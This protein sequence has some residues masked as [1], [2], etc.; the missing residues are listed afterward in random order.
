[1]KN[2][3][4]SNNNSSTLTNMCY[5]GIVDRSYFSGKFRNTSVFDV[6]TYANSFTDIVDNNLTDQNN[7]F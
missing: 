4:N 3:K 6:K 7:L 2:V 5:N 1:M